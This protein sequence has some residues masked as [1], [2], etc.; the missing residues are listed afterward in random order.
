MLIV[1][2]GWA[3]Y[4]LAVLSHFEQLWEVIN[5]TDSPDSELIE[6]A[7]SDGGPMVFAAFFGWLIALA[8]A[9]P[10]LL[11]FLLAALLRRLGGRLLR[12]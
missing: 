2:V 6:Q 5:S 12:P 7:S 3:A 10:W 8:Y 1:F 4:F 11:L 9:I